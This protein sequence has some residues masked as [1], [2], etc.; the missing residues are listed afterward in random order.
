MAGPCSWL[1]HTSRRHD[2]SCA[3][4]LA[5]PQH[6]GR[7]AWHATTTGCRLVVLR[8]TGSRL[9]VAQGPRALRGPPAGMSQGRMSHCRMSH[10]RMS[11]CRPSGYGWGALSSTPGRSESRQQTTL[12][13]LTTLAAD[14]VTRRRRHVTRRQW[15]TRPRARGAACQADSDPACSSQA[16]RRRRPTRRWRN[17]LTR[18]AG[19][20]SAWH[21]TLIRC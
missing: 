7:T 9:V 10:C 20:E 16:L 5:R 12:T 3:P 6:R 1:V 14:H 18:Q 11:H 21:A 4:H 19:S 15:P 13:T 8:T 2:G 17:P